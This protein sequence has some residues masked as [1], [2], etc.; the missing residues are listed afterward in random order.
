MCSIKLTS[1]LIF[2]FSSFTIFAHSVKSERAAIRTI[3]YLRCFLCNNACTFILSSWT[4]VR[5]VVLFSNVFTFFLLRKVKVAAELR[6]AKRPRFAFS[7]LPSLIDAVCLSQS[8]LIDAQ[9]LF[10][11][12]LSKFFKS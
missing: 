3:L 6:E 5:G 8:S 11:T 2:N 4:W 1:L 9:P 12:T 7:S 10:Q